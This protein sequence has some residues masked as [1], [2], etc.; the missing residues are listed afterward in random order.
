M[1]NEAAAALG[2]D[3][4]SGKSKKEQVWDV[5]KSASDLPE[6]APSKLTHPDPRMKDEIRSA[7]IRWIA[8][9]DVL[10]CSRFS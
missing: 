4:K 7:R 9:W 2:K 3:N 1:I 10:K 6:D 5:L 8:V